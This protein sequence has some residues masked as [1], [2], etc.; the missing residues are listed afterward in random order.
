MA[1]IYCVHYG[2]RYRDLFK[3]VGKMNTEDEVL[4]LCGEKWVAHFDTPDGGKSM[5]ITSSCQGLMI[6]V[7]EIR[8]LGGR[9][10]VIKDETLFFCD[11]DVTEG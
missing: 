6:M 4:R 1:A 8:S 11:R 7:R 2:Y 3:S 10:I 5:A 9:N